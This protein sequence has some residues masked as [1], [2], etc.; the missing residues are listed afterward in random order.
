[1]GFD[2]DG[3]TGNGSDDHRQSS[4]DF[5]SVLSHTAGHPAWASAANGNSANI[6]NRER[7]NL[8]STSELVVAGR[9]SLS[10]LCIQILQ[11]TSV[12]LRHSSYRNDGDHKHHGVLRDVEMLAMVA[13]DGSSHDRPVYCGGY[14]FLDGELVEGRR[15]RL[16]TVGYWRGTNDRHADMAAGYSGS[17]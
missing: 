16:D 15:R 2:T 17:V 13:G 11:R 6:G 7:S 12:C 1:M 9:G 3:A 14:N 10:R 8:Y 4:C 5:R